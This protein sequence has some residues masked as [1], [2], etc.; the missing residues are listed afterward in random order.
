MQMYTVILSNKIALGSTPFSRMLPIQVCVCQV[1]F[2]VSAP[3]HV[4]TQTQPGSLLAGEGQEER[5]A[6]QAVHCCRYAGCS[7]CL[8][9]FAG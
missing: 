9:F 4:S 2:S 3:S 1:L 6:A 7:S 5:V 8:P